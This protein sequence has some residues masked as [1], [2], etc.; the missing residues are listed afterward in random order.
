[1]EDINPKQEEILAAAK[2]V[3]EN[4][5]YKKTTLDDVAA[6]LTI[7]R[8]ALYYYYKNKDDL[9]LALSQYELNKYEQELKNAI[10][11][12]STIEEMLVAFCKCF[13]PKRKQFREIYKLDPEEST[14]PFAIQKK[15][16]SMNNAIHINILT[17]IFK[18]DKK[19]S[20][21]SNLGYFMTIL[22]YSIRGIVF[23]S[24]DVSAK[25]LENDMLSFFKIFYNG[26]LYTISENSAHRN[27]KDKL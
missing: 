7:S 3:F 18:N 1:M 12:C 5:G 10:N 2:K 25:Q 22:T 6:Q 11:A 24:F 16:K 27:S 23:S 17:T 20:Q 15:I 14:L 9:F 4:F 26:L 19:I 8:T 13:L 21:L